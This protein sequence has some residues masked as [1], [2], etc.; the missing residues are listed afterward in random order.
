[1]P[2]AE[3][4]RFLLRDYA[5]FVADPEALG[6]RLQA[7]RE[8]RG[9][10]TVQRWQ[11]LARSGD[12]D[13]LTVM[14]RELLEQ[15]YDPVYLKSMQRNFAGFAAAREL[16]LADGDP[17]TLHAAAALL[18]R[19]TTAPAPLPEVNAAAGSAP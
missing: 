7:L 18:A 9:A 17:P 3:R 6:H 1:M 12:P 14:V 10:E 5:H 2:L 15:H 19:E 11:A 16:P 13:S 8:L 4:V